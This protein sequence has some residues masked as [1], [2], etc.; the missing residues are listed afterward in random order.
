MILVIAF[1]V[2]GWNAGAQQRPAPPPRVNADHS[3]TLFVDVDAR[4]VVLADEVFST[5]PPGLA[6][7]KGPN[8]IWSLTTPPYEPGAHAMGVVID[9]VPTGIEFGPTW[10]DRLPQGY[11]PFDLVEVRG[12]EPLPYDLRDVPHGAIHAHTIRSEQMKRQVGLYVYTPPGYEASN[13]RYPVLYLMHTSDNASYW[14]RYGYAH[15]IMDNLIS[16]AVIQEML[17][18]MTESAGGLAADI[19][20]RYM[21]DEIIPFTERTYRVEATRGS[22]YIAGNSAGAMHARNIGFLHPEMFSAIGIMSG[23]GLNNAAAPLAT[24]YPNLTNAAKFNEQIRLLYIAFGER[25]RTSPAAN[26]QR[27]KDSLDQLGIRN[28]FRITTDGHSW[29][30]WR[31]YLAEFL[32]GLGAIQ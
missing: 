23:G 13:K 30:N 14:T 7:T 17:V 6:F 32:T 4:S 3:L 10:A 16:D 21:L 9:G 24:T 11:Y 28:D 20:E 8:G 25:D 5:A 26:G 29:F 2:I 15:R 18:V 12:E 27:L 31:R 19:G 22:R 1:L